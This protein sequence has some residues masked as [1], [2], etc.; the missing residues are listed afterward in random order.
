MSFKTTVSDK[1]VDKTNR[2]TLW[3]KLD[4]G[5]ELLLYNRDFFD[6]I[7]IGD[8]LSKDEGT[9]KYYLFKDGKKEIY[10][11]RCNGIDLTDNYTD[12]E[13]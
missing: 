12:I 13:S 8:T 10:Y 11:Q 7:E 1:Y 4:N 9:L 3:V 2:A 5:L 6:K